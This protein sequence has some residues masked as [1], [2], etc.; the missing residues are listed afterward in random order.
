MGWWGFAKRKQ[1]GVSADR[2]SPA[3]P[4]PHVRCCFL[5]FPVF[6][7]RRCAP[8]SP[9]APSPS[10]S[11]QSRLPETTALGPE[12]TAH[13]PLSREFRHGAERAEQA[14]L[15]A[16][17]R[18]PICPGAEAPHGKPLRAKIATGWVGYGEGRGRGK[19]RGGEGEGLIDHVAKSHQPLLGAKARGLKE[20]EW[21]FARGGS[22]PRAESPGRRHLGHLRGWCRLQPT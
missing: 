8:A 19:G 7:R 9:W 17:Q 22:E 20:S 5:S 14:R 16:E 1:F 21:R 11:K 15:A 2:R 4:S 18:R 6:G 3:A 13:A 10:F 12:V